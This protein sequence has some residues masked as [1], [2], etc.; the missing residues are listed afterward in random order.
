[1]G[2]ETTKTQRREEDRRENKI[3]AYSIYIHW[4]MSIVNLHAIL[5]SDK[6]WSYKS[7]YLVT[8]GIFTVVSAMLK[9]CL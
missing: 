8:M 6:M 3:E 4:P 2:G 1:M 9:L 7:A 5:T